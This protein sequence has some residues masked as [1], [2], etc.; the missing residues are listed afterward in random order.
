MK[1]KDKNKTN[2]STWRDLRPT[3]AKKPASKTARRKR[4]LGLLK[5]FLMFVC[6][7]G[8]LVGGWFVTR[9]EFSKKFYAWNQ[10]DP[11]INQVVFD[12]DGVLDHRWFQNWYG[13][14]RGRSL[15]QID[16]HK[17]QADLVHEPQISY[18]RVSR[19]FPS[20]LKVEVNEEAPVLV[21]R[22]G[23][24]GGGYKDWLVSSQ[25]DLYQGVGYARNSISLLPSLSISS[26]QLKLDPEGNG[27]RRLDG[28]EAVT[29]LLEL[30][31]REY[32]GIYRDWKVVTY[33]NPKETGPGSYVKVRAGKVKC[34]RFSPQNYAAQMKRLKYLLMEPD[35]RRKPVVESIDLSHDR[36]VFAK[37]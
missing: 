12:S 13:P 3:S 35:F 2:L 36:S 34:I 23:K 37:L 14:L 10:L 6:F 25:G 16:L 11:S 27:F 18:S 24:Q 22:L 31:R 30:A 33:A 20:T 26:Q 32:P 21:L 4:S 9:S 8:I 29:P 7:V 28:I 19:I 17:L 5:S 1:S 15:M